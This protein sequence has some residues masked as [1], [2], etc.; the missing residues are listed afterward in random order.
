MAASRTQSK[1]GKPASS[2]SET[3]A[4]RAPAGARGSK[5][6]ARTRDR[7]RRPPTRATR[8]L[9]AS[10][11]GLRGIRDLEPH[12]IDVLALAVVA[13]GIFLGGVF[14]AGWGGGTLGHGALGALELLTGKLAYLIPVA[15]VL[16][17]ARVLARGTDIAPAVRPL[18]AGMA[19]LVLASALALAAGTLGLG[20]GRTPR[21]AVW[22]AATLKP[23]GGILGGAEFA[24][25]GHLLSDAGADLLAIFL[26]VTA[27][28]LLSG[29]TF[30]S[31][32]NGS[33]H[34]ARAAMRPAGGGQRDTTGG[35]PR[36]A[37]ASRDQLDLYPEDPDALAYGPQDDEF[38]PGTRRHRAR[39]GHLPSSSCTRPAMRSFGG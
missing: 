15:L 17:G 1:S 9:V 13:I 36:R 31:F 22:A 24:V 10:R 20:P 4:K 25:A 5:A 27:A 33:R 7:A 19:C 8:S 16:T 39:A 3:A 21:H 29:A 2:R 30:A 34:H 32:L 11:P 37:A 35:D 12:Q 28:I 14:Y 23:R 26:F 38:E 6:P 18:R